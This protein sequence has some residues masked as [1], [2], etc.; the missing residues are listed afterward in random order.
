MIV[1]SKPKPAVQK[2]SVILCVRF[3]NFPNGKSYHS[4]IDY[5]FRLS[6][7][8]LQKKSVMLNLFQHLFLMNSVNQIPKQVRNDTILFPE[9]SSALCNL[10]ANCLY[11]SKKLF[12][13]VR[14]R[15]FPDGKSYHSHN[16]VPQTKFRS[17]A[18]CLRIV[19][20]HPKSQHVF[21]L[22]KL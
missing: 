13:C 20:I 15:N 3:R 12:F 17:G 10:P 9:Q 16:F 14:Y 2:K 5:F 19:S 18:A 1:I 11:T 6:S 22:L 21:F 4:H 8:S 7:E